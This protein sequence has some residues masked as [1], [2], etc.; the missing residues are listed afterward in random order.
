MIK[1]NRELTI[2]NANLEASSGRRLVALGFALL[3][4]WLLVMIVAADTSAGDDSTELAAN[5]ELSF[6]RRW[7]R[8]TGQSAAITANPELSLARR[9]VRD[10]G[11]SAAVG[12]QDNTS[13]LAANPEV[14]IA[15]RYSSSG[16]D[17][18]IALGC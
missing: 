16:F 17:C 1:R 13:F 7:Y 14:M 3:I 18:S 15:R 11:Q 5:P 9:W 6:A 12:Q 2:W 8:T 10:A 4:A